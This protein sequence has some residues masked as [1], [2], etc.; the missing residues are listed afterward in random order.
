MIQVSMI[1]ELMNSQRTDLEEMSLEIYYQ[2]VMMNIAYEI[3]ISE[4]V[5]YYKNLTN[6][7]DKISANDTKE[8]TKCKQKI[9]D[10]LKLS[11]QRFLD[12]E[13][14]YR[15]AERL[16]TDVIYIINDDCVE[17]IVEDIFKEFVYL[18]SKELKD[19]IILIIEISTYNLALKIH[20]CFAEKN[21]DMQA[22]ET[23]AL[24]NL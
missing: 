17:K 1:E 8:L 24:A 10:D 4:I 7:F 18:D 19:K 13:I 22:D 23:L 14:L 11:R 2:R 21:R 6:V 15:A 12:F 9:I 5:M 16:I 20:N 3:I